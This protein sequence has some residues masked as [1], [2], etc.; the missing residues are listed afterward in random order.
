MVKKPFRYTRRKFEIDGIA[1]RDF[2]RSS[3]EQNG[4]M[5]MAEVLIFFAASFIIIMFAA[6]MYA[7]FLRMIRD[8]RRN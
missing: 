2:F 5:F 3:T 6:M 4:K 1:I 7:A 8:S